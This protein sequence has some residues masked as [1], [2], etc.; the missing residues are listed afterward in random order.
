MSGDI[1]DMRWPGLRSK[2]WPITVVRLPGWSFSA[3][4]RDWYFGRWLHVHIG[5]WWI[6]FGSGTYD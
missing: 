4:L 2:L 6:M 3:G 5:P 1:T